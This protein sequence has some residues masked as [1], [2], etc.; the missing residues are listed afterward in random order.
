MWNLLTH[1]GVALETNECQWTYQQLRTSVGSRVEQW[2]GRVQKGQTVYIRDEDVVEQICSILT[3]LR[4][5]I[6]PTLSSSIPAHHKSLSN[7]LEHAG[8]GR[9][10]HPDVAVVFQTSGTNGSQRIVGH[11]LES[12]TYCA[13]DMVE[14]LGVT[15]RVRSALVLPLSFHYGFSVMTSTFMV[16]GTLLI[17]SDFRDAFALNTFFLR[18]KPT[19]LATVPHFW[20]LLTR[21]VDPKIWYDL[22]IC[23]FAG[24][25]CST[26]LL[27]NVWTLYPHLQLNL[28]YGSTEVL[29]SCHHRWKNGDAQ[30]IIGQPLPS[31]QLIQTDL[32]TIQTGRTLLLELVEEG[33]TK[34]V[35][36]HQWKL[37]D[38][39]SVD[40]NGVWYFVARSSDIVKV[41]GIR[42]SPVDIE[43]CFMKTTEVVD[44]V[45]GTTKGV[46]TVVLY[47]MPS[48]PLETVCVRIPSMY[49]P[50]LWLIMEEPFCTT[51]RGKRS[52]R[53]I[54]EHARQHCTAV[55]RPP[56]SVVV[57]ND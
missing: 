36:P 47:I 55:T 57:T 39:L 6:I 34:L 50:K 53:R 18:T 43:T 27:Q 19:L 15:H 10:Y 41:S 26:Q 40:P 28:F 46:L 29:R 11:R 51:D 7:E 56:F 42:L 21:I 44:V 33:Q 48:T 16:G 8:T 31:A 14:A 17:P 37:P 3:C 22:E 5:K 9:T 30:G 54:L 35:A 45:V 49:L 20:K 12:V 1:E 52:R 4:L 32:G 24:D 13:Q 2:K 25:D 23:V 38:E